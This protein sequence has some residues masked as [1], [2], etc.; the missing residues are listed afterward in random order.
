MASV[1]VYTALK[2]A[3]VAN[4]APVT[5]LD[6]DEFD[7]TKQQ[8]T[9]TF[10]VLEEV[11]EDEDLAGFGGNLC[12]L[13]S[14]VIAAHHFTPAPESSTAA[15]QFAQNTQNLLRSQ[16]L[17][18]QTRITAADPPSPTTLN[19]GLWTIYTLAISYE[20]D[21]ARPHPTPL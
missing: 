11:A 14:G 20:L 10:I 8:G 12:H 1:E 13:E 7:E 2:A 18:N 6:F 15:R 16:V 5:V 4:L 3:L 9:D 17:S 19:S 21:T